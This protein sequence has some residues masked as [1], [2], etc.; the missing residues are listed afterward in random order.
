MAEQGAFTLREDGPERVSL[1]MQRV[2]P[3]PLIRARLNGHEVV[4]AVD[5]GAP[6]LLLDPATTRVHRVETVPGERGVFWNG[7]RVAARNGWVR[8]LDLGGLVLEDVP[9][10]VTPLQKYS[11]TVNP[12]GRYI[13]G[14]IGASVLRRL[15]LTLDFRRQRVELRR[16]GTAYAPAVTPVRVPFEWW[17]EHELTVYGSLAGGRRMAL[18][19][20]TGLPEGGVGLPQETTDELGLKPDI[21]SRMA[22]GAGAVLQGRAWSAVV[23]PTVSFGAVVQDKVPAWNGAFDSRELWRH[24]VRR[25]ALIGPDTFTR[26]R[27]SFDWDAMTL[28]FE[29]KD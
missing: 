17:G 23:V 15:G 16:P 7:G 14:V 29:S 24:G 1:L 20:G 19:L 21:L 2:W 18:L 28:L 3:V 13:Q 12:Q 22:K 6:D 5:P 10:A 8:S 11:L 9:A 26:R 27:V 4:L 25:D